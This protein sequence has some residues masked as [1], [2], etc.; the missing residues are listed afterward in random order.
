MAVMNPFIPDHLMRRR[1]QFL[2]AT[3]LASCALHPLPAQSRTFDYN[4][5]GE[6]KSK[7]GDTLIV[8]RDSSRVDTASNCTR[9]R[10]AAVTSPTSTPL[11]PPSAP[12]NP[13]SNEPSDLVPLTEHRM[14]CLPASCVARWGSQNGVTFVRDV[15]AR[16]S[17]LLRQTFTSALPG[18]S[19][20]GDVW[21]T[22]QQPLNTL[23]VAYWMRL[24]S[25]FVGHPTS[26]NKVVHINIDGRNRIY[27]ALRG[28]GDGPL[29]PWFGL[30][31][32]FASYTGTDGGVG[33]SANIGPNLGVT[34]VSV[35]RG[36]WHKFEVL[37]VANTGT[38]TLWVDGV[39][40]MHHVGIAFAQPG[41]KWEGFA[42][43]PTWGGAGGTITTSF[44][45]DVDHIYVS[46]K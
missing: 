40:I 4:C 8:Q 45:A 29:V 27:T 32:L 41:A 12:A 30:Q 5:V 10:S 9:K 3:L 44:S 19:S 37:L 17:A 2:L 18:G 20:P 43:S 36:A 23:Y 6:T 34:N 28:V 26:W 39:K 24:S 14:H 25:N 46:G 16:D 38:A 11:P 42:W 33:T 21:F 15:S 22:L 7:R 1:W 13:G 31:A 35:S